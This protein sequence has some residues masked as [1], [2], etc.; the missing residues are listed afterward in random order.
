V[1][2]RYAAEDLQMFSRLARFCRWGFL[3]ARLVR[4]RVHATS[5]S[6]SLPLAASALDQLQVLRNIEQWIP[7][8]PPER[9]AVR[10]KYADI[11]ASAG[12]HCLKIGDQRQALRFLWTAARVAPTP[13]AL[14]LLAL[15]LLPRSLANG[16]RRVRSG[17]LRRRTT[18][19]ITS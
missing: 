2:L 4:R 9:R 10:A 11:A 8:T 6:H 13:N 15:A 5:L 7:L 3:T 19:G 12:Y 14:A 16:L 18:Q 1:S 17:Q